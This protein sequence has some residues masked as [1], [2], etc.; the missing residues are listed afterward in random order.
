LLISGEYSD[1]A[2]TCGDMTFKVHKNIVYTL[3]PSF[4]S[5][6]PEDGE[7]VRF[8]SLSNTSLH[9]API[10][11]NR[12]R[13]VPAHTAINLPDDEPEIIKL[14]LQ[15]I[16]TG[17]YTTGELQPWFPHTCRRSD[18]HTELCHQHTCGLECANT[19]ADFTCA[20]CDFERPFY[21]ADNSSQLLVQAK[22]YHAASKYALRSFA[23]LHV[24][25]S[26]A[27]SR[28]LLEQRSICGG[29]RICV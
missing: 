1:I 25:S 18:C 14:F 22:L 10:L 5:F 23:I 29:G 9:F 24:R 11:I 28:D 13:Q 6:D 21:P 3:C 8:F 19:C 16:Y 12:T 7:S 20:T 2:I 15:F 26:S 27:S 4:K 17:E